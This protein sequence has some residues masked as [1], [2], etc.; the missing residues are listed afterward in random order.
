MN[1]DDLYALFM[2]AVAEFDSS[3]FDAWQL[4]PAAKI[5]DCFNRLE[6]G[7]RASF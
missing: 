7:S 2:H 3:L 4:K 1:I 6:T 5:P